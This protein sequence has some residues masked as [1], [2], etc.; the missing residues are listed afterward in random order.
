MRIKFNKEIEF[1]FKKIFVPEKY[2][3]KKRLDRAFKKIYE[4]D[5]L[6]LDQ[7]TNKDR[8]SID[9]G[10][11]KGVYSYHLSQL[12]KH[13]NSFEPNPLIFSYINKNLKK[14]IKNITLYNVALSDKETELDLRIPKRFNTTIK[15]NYE[16]RFKLGAATIH[17]KNSFDNNEYVAFKVKTK[18]LDNLLLEKNIGFIKIDVE[19]H[20]KNVLM[21]AKNLIEKNKPNLLIEIEELHSKEKVENTIGYINNF[22]YK[23]YFCENR[24][25]ISTNKLSNYK[26]KNNYVFLPQ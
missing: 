18:K 3:L 2:L 21:G 23:S 8:E 25:L 11:Y 12:S 14:I 16:E 7:I 22:G 24:N 20:E 17:Q 13:V 9:V 10:V 15:D 1:L 4:E 26:L 6:I 5:L 19:G